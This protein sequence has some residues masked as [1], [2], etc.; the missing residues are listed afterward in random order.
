MM[1]KTVGALAAV[2][3]V[4]TF[5]AGGRTLS[6]AAVLPAQDTRPTCSNCPATYI[7]S[8]EVQAYVKR[9]I[10]RGG[11]VADQQMRAVN[12][13]KSNV[14]VGLVYPRVVAVLRRRNN[15]RRSTIR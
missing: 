4:T 11:I 5:A 13:G 12:I 9:G 6:H 2:A 7:A 10:A 1:T 14:D 8:D 15:R 3:A